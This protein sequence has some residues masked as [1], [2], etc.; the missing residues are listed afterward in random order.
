MDNLDRNNPGLG[1][2]D[3]ENHPQFISQKDYTTAKNIRSLS[4]AGQTTGSVESVL[5]NGYEAA[6]TV[7]A[8]TTQ[9]KQVR[10]ACNAEAGGNTTITLRTSE[11]GAAITTGAITVTLNDVG[12]SLTDMVTEIN[13][14]LIAAGYLGCTE[15]TSKRDIDNTDFGSS[16]I[17]ILGI[18]IGGTTYTGFDWVIEVTDFFTVI[19]TAQEGIP[20]SLI[21][22]MVCIG[23]YD[24]LN[25]LFT[26]WTPQRNEPD[27]R[28]IIFAVPVGISNTIRITERTAHDLATGDEVVISGVSGVTGANGK[29]IVEVTSTTEYE[30]IGSSGAGLLAKSI[31]SVTVEP[32]SGRAIIELATTTDLGN[33]Q[34]VFVTMTGNADIDDQEWTIHILNTT[35]VAL[36]NSVTATPSGAVGF[37]SPIANSTHNHEGYLE[38]GVAQKNEADETWTYIRLIGA[39]A[40]NCVTTHQ[41]DNVIEINGGRVEF[42]FTDN[43]NVPRV[44]YYKGDY[45]E[46]GFLSETTFFTGQ[47][48][49]Y[50]Y[51]DLDEAS[52]LLLSTPDVDCYFSSQRDGGGALLSGNYRYVARFSVDGT[53][54]GLPTE[55][56]GI[57]NVFSATINIAA[58]IAGDEAQTTTG[59]QNVIRIDN[60]P[61]VFNYVELIA[62]YYSEGAVAAYSVKIQ[63]LDASGTAIITHEAEGTSIDASELFVQQPDILTA[64]NI[65]SLDQRLILGNTTAHEHPDLADWAAEAINNLL[66]RDLDNV[67]STGVGVGSAEQPVFGE[68]QDPRNTSEGMGYMLNETYRFGVELRYAG[69]DIWTP[70]YWVDDIPFNTTG[71]TRTLMPLTDYSI[72]DLPTPSDNCIPKVIFPSFYNLDFDYVMP[73]NGKAIRDMFDKIRFVRAECN[74]TILAEGVSILSIEAASVYRINNNWY[75]TAAAGTTTTPDTTYTA[76]GV[77]PRRLIYTVFPDVLL[78]GTT[79]QY[80]SG[81]Q[82]INY[83]NPTYQNVQNTNGGVLPSTCAQ[84]YGDAG[85]SQT[86]DISAMEYAVVNFTIASDTVSL[87]EPGG[88]ILVTYPSYWIKT[89]ADLTDTNGVA[90]YGIYRVQYYRPNASQYGSLEST[91]YIPTGYEFDITADVNDLTNFHIF[92]GDVF[93]QKSYFSVMYATTAGGSGQIAGFYSQNRTNSQMR[94]FGGTNERVHPKGADASG[95]WNTRIN[96]VTFNNNRELRAYD[97][98]YNWNYSLL[99]DAAFS[100]STNYQTD[101]NTRAWYSDIKSANSLQDNYRSF[102]ALNYKDLPTSYGDLLHMEILSGELYTWQPRAMTR[103][104]FNT[105]AVLQ[106]GDDTQDITV[107]SGTVFAVDGKVVTNIG[108]YHKWSVIKGRSLSGSDTAAWINT[109]VK[110]ATKF[111]AA[112]TGVI[113][114]MRKMRAFFANNLKWATLY[115]TPAD[116]SGICGVWSDRYSSFIWTV[117]ASASPTAYDNSTNYGVTIPPTTVSYTPSLYQR[118]FEQTTEI[119]ECIQQT[120]GGILPTNTDYWRKISHDDGT[121]YNE[122]TLT[123]NEVKNE[124]ETFYSFKPTIYLKWQDGFL[125]TRPLSNTGRAYEHDKGYYMHWYRQQGDEGVGTVTKTEGTLV[126][127]GAGTSFTTTMQAGY[128]ILVAGEMYFVRSVDSN[129][130]LT[131][132]DYLIENDGEGDVSETAEA[133]SFSGAVYVI[134]SAQTEDGNITMVQNT[135]PQDSKIYVA[136]QHYTEVAPYRVE[137]ETE[138]N[139]SYLDEAE[140]TS[141][142]D[143][144]WSPIKMDSTST[145]LNSDDTSR[146][147]GKYL[148]TDIKIRYLVFQK[149]F[150]LITKSRLRFRR[151]NT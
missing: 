106:G 92:G 68:Y 29:W 126:I 136:Q 108:T 13:A 116:G 67:V 132:D 57:V 84:L 41:I 100:E 80:Q 7:P 130:Q 86:V 141:R 109:E 139:E 103:Q 16:V 118:N 55:P 107:G 110:K 19:G 131:I 121:Y 115:T 99:F 142:I 39:K 42:Y 5:G 28:D 33:N 46:D 34:R 87:N 98:G 128:G 137:Y 113:S 77:N 59:K 150:S 66:V 105:R 22:E 21:G 138:D 50:N 47:I 127:T 63:S 76:P 35:Q 82:I 72:T 144:Y 83:G 70:A 85:G 65:R 27:T 12:A 14:A 30:L 25:D 133:A 93:N 18:D 112:G 11:D 129:T 61:I 145:G 6:F 9:N 81:D 147:M 10:I 146:I 51:D 15:I 26:Y 2:L 64:L 31:V 151:F 52:Q 45:I 20:D 44:M 119:Y 74:P 135:Q 117:R 89:A 94:Q 79:L 124:W 1:G 102:L 91:Q 40:F 125:T 88:T 53:T 54:Y 58:A 149:I 134:Y 143:Y 32:V 71:S 75:Y 37:L 123:Y 90:D 24:L 73:E 3:K 140:F 60:I 56:T 148:F 49:D 101:Y 120:G 62:I 95:T 48:N 38:I 97:V 122:Y 17:E 4:Q 36:I 69:S 104:F 111:D 43:Y 78:G 114:D 96:D 23:S 8:L